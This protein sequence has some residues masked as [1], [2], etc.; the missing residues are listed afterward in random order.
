VNTALRAGMS[1]LGVLGAGLAV[2]FALD[3]AHPDGLER[4]LDDV[5][6]RSTGEVVVLGSS[7]TLSAIDP[8]ALGTELGLPA[9]AA[10]VLALE[11]TGPAVWLATY[12][13]ARREGLVPRVVLLYVPVNMVWIPDA[14]ADMEL[15]LLSAL[16]APP[17]AWAL[18]RTERSPLRIRADELRFRG[19]DALLEAISGWAAELAWPAARDAHR[20]AS[21]RARAALFEDHTPNEAAAQAKRLDGAG[22]SARTGLTRPDVIDALVAAARADGA[23]LVVVQPAQSPADLRRPCGPVVLLPELEAHLDNARVD[24][25]DL[26]TS[27]PDVGL[28]RTHHHLTHEGASRLTATLAA[29]LRA[30]HATTTSTD[31]PARRWVA[32][33]PQG[34]R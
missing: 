13:H 31:T 33:C 14:T 29:G 7:V 4:R 32:P 25:L 21:T 5:I 22:A 26:A 11:G 30:I 18:A 16:D 27:L 12:A 6:A 20:H 15:A 9:N 2:A 10:R 1:F 24:L 3:H 19:R 23:R 28:F 34:S 8:E 17:A